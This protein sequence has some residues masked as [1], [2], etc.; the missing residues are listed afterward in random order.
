MLQAF[1]EFDSSEEAVR[2]MSAR[3]GDY[4]GDRY[5]K[6]LRVPPE[7]MEEQTG[8]MGGGMLVNS[9][10]G[11][12]QGVSAAFGGMQPGFAPGPGMR[13]Q[14]PGQMLPQRPTAWGQVQI[15]CSV[16]M[17]P[18][19]SGQ[20]WSALPALADGAPCGLSQ[21]NAPAEQSSFGQQQGQQPLGAFGATGQEQGFGLAGQQHAN[22]GGPGQGW[23][24]MT[25]PQAFGGYNSTQPQ[26]QQGP[27]F[28][29]HQ[30]NMLSS[31]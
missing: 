28:N 15:H 20:Q 27:G 2:A 4:I 26:Q 18:L 16:C 1:A 14:Q 5:V 22:L 24:P 8:G 12:M 17:I 29:G 30:H 10:P 7:E 23:S 25:A 11:G 21:G 6:L 9:A 19:Y 13:P 3:N 31:G